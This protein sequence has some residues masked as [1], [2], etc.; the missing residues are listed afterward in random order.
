MIQYSWQVKKVWWV[1][2]KIKH[3]KY[4]EMPTSVGNVKEVDSSDSLVDLVDILVFSY[5]C[6]NYAEGNL[7]VM[8]VR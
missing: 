3:M 6:W 1:Y 7:Y 4:N 2:H 5:F 8:K